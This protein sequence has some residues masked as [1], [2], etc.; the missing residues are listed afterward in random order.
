MAHVGI[1]ATLS[2][3]R[4]A[5]LVVDAI[6]VFGAARAGRG[7]VAVAGAPGL[8]QV[9]RDR[10][11]EVVVFGGGLGVEALP[12]ADGELA[13]LVVR[14]A[15]PREGWLRAVRPGGAVVL[16]S[17]PPAAEQSRRALCAGLVDL[18]QRRAGRLVVTSGRTPPR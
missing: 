18:E 8:A 17:A 15:E 3:G 10:G 9:L 7:T 2:W 6:S 12:F 11:L 16:V 4:G 5:R 1:L 13:A 14:G